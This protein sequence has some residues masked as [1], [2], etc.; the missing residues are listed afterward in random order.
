LRFVN[1]GRNLHRVG[2]LLA[3]S[4]AEEN[5][6]NKTRNA[7]LAL[8]PAVAF[9]LLP[10][11]PASAHDHGYGRGHGRGFGPFGVVGA[12]VGVT[13]AIVAAPFIIA[14]DTARAVEPRPL[15]YPP[16]PNYA[17]PPLRAYSPPAAYY[18]G[19][20]QGYYAPPPAYYYP[21]PSGYYPAR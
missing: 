6:M 21:A 11:T 10:L 2:G 19:P 20:P 17:Y 14:A 3:T 9:A 4:P 13:A 16:A 1:I 12:V 15:Y 8:V 5:T 18:Y 7:L